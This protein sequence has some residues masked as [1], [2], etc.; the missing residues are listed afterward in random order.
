M[1][2][3]YLP[4]LLQQQPSPPS[5]GLS[6]EQRILAIWAHVLLKQLLPISS[7]ESKSRRDGKVTKAGSG[8]KDCL[9]LENLVNEAS[10]L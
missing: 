8:G 5:R 10:W 9:D 2:E 7:T 4:L 3:L 6:A 1:A